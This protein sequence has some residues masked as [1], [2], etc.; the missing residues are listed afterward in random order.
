LLPMKRLHCMH[1]KPY[2]STG[3]M[4]RSVGYYD[5]CSYIFCTVIHS[6]FFLF[7]G[8]PVPPVVGTT[9]GYSGDERLPVCP[10]CGTGFQ[11][12]CE[13]YRRHTS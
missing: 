4:K 11:L 2:T 5:A 9:A 12:S 10:V 13:R 7:V 1:I 6:I 8:F 3:R